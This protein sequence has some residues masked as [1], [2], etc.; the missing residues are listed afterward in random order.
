MP[1]AN[2]TE[3]LMRRLALAILA[4][5]TLAPA[6][7]ASAQTYDPSYPVCLHVYGRASY[8]ECRYT[9]IAQCDG[10]ASGRA[11]QCIVNPY[12]APYFADAS[13]EPR[14]HRRHQRAY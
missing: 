13:V 9:S 11:A 8:Y 4:V 1:A 2:P 12:F 3:V 10:S 6:A 14:R 5:G 7:P